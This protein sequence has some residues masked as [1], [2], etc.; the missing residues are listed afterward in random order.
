MSAVEARAE[1]AEAK[2]L[3]LDAEIAN[4]KL[5]IAKMKRNAFGASSERGAKLIEQLEL[6]LA[7]LVETVIET[8]V[9]AEI[10]NPES[11]AA[12]DA[13]KPARRP[14][15]EHLP[16]EPLVHAAPKSAMLQ[17]DAVPQARRGH[18]REPGAHARALE[19]DRPCA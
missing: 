16:R 18:H 8:K 5:T 11:A 19:G 10:G 13:L 3:D 17:R 12:P 2:V 7:E 14:L 1:A 4:L 15:P 9:A 6:Q